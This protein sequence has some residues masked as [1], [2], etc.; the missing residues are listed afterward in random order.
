MCVCACACVCICTHVHACVCVFT[1]VCVCAYVVNS[2]RF[3]DSPKFLNYSL[4][5]RNH[6]LEK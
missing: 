4:N 5:L 6:S 2:G 3:E 1:F